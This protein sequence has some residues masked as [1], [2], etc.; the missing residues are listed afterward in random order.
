MLKKVPADDNLL[1]T[2][3][4]DTL[5]CILNRLSYCDIERPQTKDNPYFINNYV[6]PWKQPVK[7][8][9]RFPSVAYYSFEIIYFYNFCQASLR[10]NLEKGE[11]PDQALEREIYKESGFQVNFTELLEAYRFREMPRLGLIYKGELAQSNPFTPSD[12]V[13]DTRLFPLDELPKYP[14]ISIRCH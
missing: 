9:R 1:T 13:Q 8:L 5:I 4:L 12:E 11:D 2:N 14:H 6:F 7:I 10:L 3:A